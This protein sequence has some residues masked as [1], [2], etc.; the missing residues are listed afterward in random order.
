MKKFRFLISDRV[1]LVSLF[2]LS[3][4][5]LLI[6][7]SFQVTHPAEIKALR[8]LT[9]FALGW[10]GFSALMQK[11]QFPNRWGWH[12]LAFFVNLFLTAFIGLLVPVFFFSI[13]R[14]FS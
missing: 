10:C 3:I 5:S 6:V 14:R 1:T 9:I 2:H 13:L 12:L 4:L 7:L 11:G 8:N